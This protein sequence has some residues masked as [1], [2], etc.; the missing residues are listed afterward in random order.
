MRE[1]EYTKDQ[2]RR[3]KKIASVL[4]GL[5]LDNPKFRTSTTDWNN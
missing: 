4:Y 2:I 1:P 3:A 5:D